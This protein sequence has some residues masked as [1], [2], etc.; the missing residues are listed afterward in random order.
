MH[1]GPARLFFFFFFYLPPA[2]LEVDK[3]RKARDRWKCEKRGRRGGEGSGRMSGGLLNEKE[4]RRLVS[5]QVRMARGQ[6]EEREGRREPKRAL[7]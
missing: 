4:R 1:K 6:G 7:Q 5:S 2:F 3:E